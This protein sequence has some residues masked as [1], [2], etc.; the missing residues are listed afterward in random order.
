MRAEEPPMTAITESV[1]VAVP[2]AQVPNLT[3]RYLAGFPSNEHEGVHFT[4]RAWVGGI[5]AEHEILMKVDAEPDRPALEVV[6]IHWQ[7][8]DGGPYPEFTGTLSARP[9][10]AGSC[11]L[12]LAGSYTP[13]GGAA[14][15]AFD[16]LLGHNIAREGARDVLARFKSAFEAL[17][18]EA[19]ASSSG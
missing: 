17:H 2:F 8:Q 19:A 14:G 10:D 18:A 1:I 15:A 13:P 4:L 6:D 9:V 5:V 7:S 12:E 3:R 11:T 16:A